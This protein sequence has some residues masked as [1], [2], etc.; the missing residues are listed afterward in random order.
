[1]LLQQLPLRG[2]RT[3]IIAPRVLRIADPVLRR[4][5]ERAARIRLDERAERGDRARVIAA[6]E[7]V[8][9][10]VVGTLLGPVAMVPPPA[11]NPADGVAETNATPEGNASV[12]VTFPADS[13]PRLVAV[14]V[15]VKLLFSG[16]GLGAAVLARARSA[17]AATVISPFTAIPNPPI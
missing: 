2:D 9:R 4:R 17:D 5:R 12:T 7:L 6:L 14:R 16:T 11:R 3:A 1:M 13:G 15:N 8:E 10:S